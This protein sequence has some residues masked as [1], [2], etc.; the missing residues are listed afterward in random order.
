MVHKN[1]VRLRGNGGFDQRQ[2]RRDTGDH[3][4]NLEAT[5]HLQPIGAIVLEALGLKQRIQSGM[6]VVAVSHGGQIWD[7]ASLSLMPG[8]CNSMLLSQPAPAAI[9]RRARA[10]STPAQTGATQRK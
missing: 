1:G 9:Q 5:F 7:S 2:A 4:T 6:K 3:R 8:L 10:A